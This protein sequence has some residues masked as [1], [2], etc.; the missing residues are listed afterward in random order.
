MIKLICSDVDGTLVPDGTR[1]INPEIFDV[2]CRLKEQGI[3][4]AIASGRPI[5]SIRSLFRPIEDKLFFIAVGGSEIA[6]KS[7]VLF[8]WDMDRGDI[9]AMIRDGRRIPGCEILMNGITASYL[10][11]KDREFYN[12]LTDGY[13]TETTMADDL[14]TVDDNIIALSFYHRGH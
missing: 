14:L 9:E 1:D 10:E 3:H 2:I 8:H 7:R 12:W 4:F 5:S 11:T 13:G 6:T